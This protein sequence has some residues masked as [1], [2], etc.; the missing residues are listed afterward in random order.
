MWVY[1]S[2]K[3]EDLSPVE[4]REARRASRYNRRNWSSMELGKFMN[5][6]LCCGCLCDNDWTE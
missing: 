6:V 3:L 5:C 4:D 1:L 2:W